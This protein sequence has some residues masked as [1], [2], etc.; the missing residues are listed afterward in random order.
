M[1]N[2]VSVA[3]AISKRDTE[4]ITIYANSTDVPD[5]LMEIKHKWDKLSETTKHLGGSCTIGDGFEFVYQEIPY[6]MSPPCYQ[7]SL[8]YE[9]W[10]DTIKEDLESAGAANV[11]YNYG[12]MD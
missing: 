1:G 3:N 10:I 2:L 12:W 9:H 11:Y 4:T 8:I 5:V 6:Q 7:G